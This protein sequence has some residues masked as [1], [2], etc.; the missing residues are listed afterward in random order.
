MNNV[1]E[2]LNLINGIVFVHIRYWLNLTCSNYSVLSIHMQFM[3]IHQQITLASQG[4]LYTI[5]S[6]SD[7]IHVVCCHI[8]WAYRRVA[9]FLLEWFS[10]YSKI[11]LL[12]GYFILPV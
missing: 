6:S 5:G 7:T 12:L 8:V 10:N 3:P 2:T 9:N 1:L 4:K 11:E